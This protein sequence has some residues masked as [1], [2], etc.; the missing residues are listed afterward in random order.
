MGGLRNLLA[1]MELL[2]LKNLQILNNLLIFCTR[3]KPYKEIY[4]I[5]EADGLA[6]IDPVDVEII[7]DAHHVG[8]QVK[9]LFLIT[10]DYKHIVKRGDLIIRNTSLKAVIGLGEFNLG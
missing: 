7:I 9:D 10:G 3:D 4:Q 2:C 8:L 6:Q 1:D 5:F